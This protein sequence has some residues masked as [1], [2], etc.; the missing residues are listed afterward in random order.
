MPTSPI[1]TVTDRAAARIETLTQDGE[2]KGAA[3]RIEVLGGGCSGFQYKMDLTHEVKDDDLIFT[4]STARV[5]IDPTSIEFVS[6]SGLDYVE[7]IG[8]AAFAIT[9]P[10]AKA[11]CGC[12]NSFSV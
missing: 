8:S 9:N 12:G 4:N 6:G 10:N 3:F 7:T 5:L 1:F 2:D 11:N